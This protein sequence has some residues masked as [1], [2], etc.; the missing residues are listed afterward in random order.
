VFES[1]FDGDLDDYLGCMAREIPDD[2]ESVWSHCVGYPGVADVAKF[3][4][5]MKKCQLTTTFYFA[6]VNN[7]TV[8]QTLRALQTQ[9]ALADFIEQNQ[10]KPPAELQQALAVF[11]N[12]K[13][14]EPAPGVPGIGGMPCIETNMEWHLK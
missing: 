7:K 3:T 8:Q 13:R 1:N 14:P 9:K 4:E 11:L 12:T 5:Y 10:G 2:V 6:D